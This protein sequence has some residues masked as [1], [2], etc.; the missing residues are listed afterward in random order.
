MNAYVLPKV[1][2]EELELV[3]SPQRMRDVGNR[4]TLAGWGLGIL[5][6]LG[7]AAYAALYTGRFPSGGKQ[8]SDTPTP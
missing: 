3:F 2:P 6:C 5:A 4:I 1:P 8:G 7:C